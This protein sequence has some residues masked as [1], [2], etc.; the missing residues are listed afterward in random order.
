M[1]PA[2]TPAAGSL[3]SSILVGLVSMLLGGARAS[4]S[5]G[6]DAADLDMAHE[7][8]PPRL[9]GVQSLITSDGD[10]RIV[11]Q[12]VEVQPWRPLV[13]LRMRY[14]DGSLGVGTG[15][16]ITPTV[17]LTAAH[18]LY[19]LDLGKF[20]EAAVA[21]VGVKNGAPGAQARIKR[22][23]VCPGYTRQSARNPARYSLDFGVAKVDSD[24][25]FRW[26]GEVVPVHEQEPVRDDELEKSLLNVAGY[27]DREGALKLKTDAGG[28]L[29]GT[30][31]AANFRYKIDTMPG[32]SGGP[33]F[34]FH[35]DSGQFVYAGVHVAGDAASNLARR[36]DPAMRNQVRAW[37][38]SMA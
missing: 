36:Y 17:I 38:S 14:A 25:L 7:P 2:Q 15:I 8:P 22:V 33:V 4:A 35:K 31:S 21:E 32:Q 23:E 24:A 26:A 12:D 5:G 18:N 13:C 37:L 16:L 30:L 9:S 19:A 11:V 1:P 34:R 29:K 3:L 6:G 28:V 20:V 27:P 10:Q